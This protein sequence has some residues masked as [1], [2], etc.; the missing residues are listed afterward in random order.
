MT[1]CNY[2]SMYGD[3]YIYVASKL[4]IVART[5]SEVA[6]YVTR[7][8]TG[9]YYYV[10]TN[11]I[12]LTQIYTA[13]KMVWTGAYKKLKLLY[14]FRFRKSYGNQTCHCVTFSELHIQL[15]YISIA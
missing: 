11:P 8:Y 15:P 2:N 7:K 12:R 14:N 5:P 6:Q 4:L 10:L 3:F 1:M 9:L 13:P